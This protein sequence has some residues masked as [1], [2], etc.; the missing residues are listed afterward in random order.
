MKK[1]II[2]AGPIPA[3]LDSVKIITNMFKGGL[4]VKTA[5]MLQATGEFDVE[6]VKWKGTVVK[7]Q[8]PDSPHDDPKV[9]SVNDLEEYRTYIQKT[10]ADA[11]ILAA[12]VANLM[13]TNPWEGKFPSHKYHVGQRFPIEFCIAPRIIDE[14]KK[15]HPRSTLI[16]YKLFDG[17]DE[18]LVKAGWETLCGSRS[19]VVFCNH[20]KTAAKKKITLLPDGTE[21]P[22]D[23]D[24]HVHFIRRVINLEWY[25]TQT[26]SLIPNEDWPSGEEL[27][28]MQRVLAFIQVERPP[29]KF[30]TI[31]RR[32]ENGFITTTRGKREGPF[33][34]VFS[35]D[36]DL[37]I[38]KASHK[39]TMNAPTIERLFEEWPNHKWL[40]HQHE[41]LGPSYDAKPYCF[42]GTT[43]EVGLIDKMRGNET[44]IFQVE[45]HGYYAL[46]ETQEEVEGWLK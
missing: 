19:N 1:V 30:G 28:W 4:A 13:P 32:C 36:H 31:A 16:G 37:R 33:C 10:D 7:F 46:F 23:F 14:V 15:H 18:E 22:M 20:P 11:Y 6:I 40:L 44:R 43:E 39:A 45:G 3:R 9:T 2:T 25:C 27:E 26:Q 17:S 21:I 8:I 35:V 42:P 5:E 12:A 34:K 24:E 38:V 29:Y 41:K